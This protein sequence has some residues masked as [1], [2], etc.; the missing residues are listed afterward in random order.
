MV[1]SDCYA[2]LGIKATATDDEIRKAYRKKALQYHPDKNSSSTAEEIFKEINKAY[3]TLGDAD[4]RRAYDLQQ[5]TTNIKFTSSSSSSQHRR[6]EPSFHT[7]SQSHFTSTNNNNSSRFRC[8]D[9]FFNL[10]QRHAY[11]T[12]KMHSPNFS[13]FDTNFGSS[14]DDETDSDHFDPILSTFHSSQRHFRRKTRSKWHHNR[15]FESDPFSMFEM[16]TRSI[17]DQFLKDDFFWHRSSARLHNAS[18]QPQQRTTTTTTTTTPSTNRTRIPVNH[19]TPTS[20]H[21]YEMKRTSMSSSHFNSKDSDDEDIDE[22]FIY[23]EAK[24]TTTTTNDHHFRRH[25]YDNKTTPTTTTTNKQKFEACQYCFHQIT[26]IENLLKH[27]AIC[28]HRPDQEKVY[29]TKC[30]YCQENI[31]LN[32]YLDHEEICKQNRLNRQPT[33]NKRY[34]NPLSK[35]LYDENQPSSKSSFG[36]LSSDNDKL[37]TCH[38]CHKIFPVLSDLFNHTCDDENDLVLSKSTAPST[39]SDNKS[40]NDHTTSL[41]DKISS[42][43][44]K[45]FKLSRHPPTFNKSPISSS[46]IHRLINPPPTSSSLLSTTISSA[47]PKQT[48]GASIHI[49]IVDELNRPNRSSLENEHIP[50][51]KRPLYQ[52]DLTTSNHKQQQPPKHSSSTYV[53]LRNPSSSPIRVNS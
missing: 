38:R 32:E 9:P 17:F 39:K 7:S 8:H 19:V 44:T 22:H 4:K 1:A 46:H 25:A 53:Y 49:S 13:F 36:G 6:Y 10:H 51:F 50:M 12:S 47:I 27:E 42:S 5:Q 52:P 20:K 26:P 3:E 14:D 2:T 30:S 41:L 24:P 11:F 40:T 16:L 21:R 48:H 35:C 23:Q 18:Q 37:R 33:E 45:S 15:P 43:S 31:R 28:R 34:Y 29:T